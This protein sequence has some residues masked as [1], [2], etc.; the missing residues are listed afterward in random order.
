MDLVLQLYEGPA[1]V[2]ESLAV[3]GET[4]SRPHGHTDSSRCEATTSDGQR[5]CI[6]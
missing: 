5:V 1:V 2:A 4:A 3:D 6:H